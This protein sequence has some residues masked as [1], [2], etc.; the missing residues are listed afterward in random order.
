MIN[1]TKTLLGYLSDPE[2][3]QSNSQPASGAVSSAMDLVQA[4]ND[5]LESEEFI[6]LRSEMP[7]AAGEQTCTVQ[8]LKCDV[9]A[10]SAWFY[11][12]SCAAIFCVPGRIYRNL[13]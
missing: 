5:L 12:R 13:C 4:L 10:L 8:N 9:S 11:F 3:S 1:E 6:E 7:V 2:E